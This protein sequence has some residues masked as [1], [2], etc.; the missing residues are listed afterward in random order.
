MQESHTSTLWQLPD[1]R[2]ALDRHFIFLASTPRPP[3]RLSFPCRVAAGDKIDPALAARVAQLGVDLDELL[4]EHRLA[5]I[6][7]D[8][9]VARGLKV[10]ARPAALAPGGKRGSSSSS[11]STGSGTGSSTGS[12]T[13]SGGN[14]GATGRRVGRSLPAAAAEPGF[15]PPAASGHAPERRMKGARQAELEI[16]PALAKVSEV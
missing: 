11:S 13:G 7:W 15:E 1:V 2:C 10:G 6:A 9:D 4:P 14:G 12:G 3:P 5:A 8:A 16:E